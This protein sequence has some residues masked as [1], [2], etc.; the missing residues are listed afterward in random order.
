VG[1]L[2]RVSGVSSGGIEATL[3]QTEAQGL[4][5]KISVKPLWLYAFEEGFR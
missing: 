3:G 2:A 1:R 5:G 4:E